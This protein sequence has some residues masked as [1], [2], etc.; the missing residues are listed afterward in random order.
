MKLFAFY[1]FVFS[2]TAEFLT[3]IFFRLRQGWCGG[4]GAAR[5]SRLTLGLVHL[6]LFAPFRIAN[7]GLKRHAAYRNGKIRFIKRNNGYATWL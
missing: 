4:G 6:F 2:L 7:N 3:D 1:Y 5:V